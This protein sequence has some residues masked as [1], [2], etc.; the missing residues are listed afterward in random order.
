M[1]KKK[2]RQVE[3]GARLRTAREIAGLSQA[4]VAKLLSLH[5][6]SVSEMEAGRRKVS[7]EELAMLVE[8]YDVK[9]SW[10]IGSD[11]GE[12]SADDEKI[13]LA[14]RQLAKLKP[15]DYERVLF[16]LSVLRSSKGEH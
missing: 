8:A 3:I 11:T 16:L 9:L 6:P 2:S 7:A 5:R 1:G 14:A 12:G 13:K 4:Q 10:V 15:K